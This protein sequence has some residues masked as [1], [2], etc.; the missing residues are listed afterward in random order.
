MRDNATQFCWG[1]LT[2]KITVDSTSKNILHDFR[3][4]NV[5]KVQ[6]SMN[7]VFHK[8]DSDDLPT[9]KNPIM[10]TI[11]PSTNNDNKQIFYKCVYANLIGLRIIKSL[12][13]TSLA[14]LKLKESKYLW[15]SNTGEEFYDG[16]TMLQMCVEK[17]NPN[18]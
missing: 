8:K 5:D 11:D 2:A 12:D 7:R 16:P 18:T 4:I 10:F 3:D 13:K 9:G 17:V 6:T 1:I 14:S 15:I